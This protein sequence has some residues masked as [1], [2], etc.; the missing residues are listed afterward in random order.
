MLIQKQDIKQ[1]GNRNKLMYRLI[2]VRLGF[3]V[4]QELGPI[5]INKCAYN[6]IS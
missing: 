3:K 4:D 1:K 2:Q 5:N 6:D